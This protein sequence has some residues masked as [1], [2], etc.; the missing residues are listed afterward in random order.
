MKLFEENNVTAVFAGHYHR[1]SYANDGS[2]EMIT[3]GPVGKPLGQD[4]S[5][6]RIVK[7][8][9]DHIEHKYYGLDAVPEIVRMHEE[10]MTTDAH[11]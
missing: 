10:A 6:F 1:N 2:M 4:P 8:F 7:V 11:R 9:K 3:S 5:G